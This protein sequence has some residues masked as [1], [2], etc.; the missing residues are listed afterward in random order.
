MIGDEATTTAGWPGTG[1]GQRSSGSDIDR[2]I[3][4]T[5]ESRRLFSNPTTVLGGLVSG[6]GIIERIEDD[7]VYFRSGDNIEITRQTDVFSP[8]SGDEPPRLVKA[9]VLEEGMVVSYSMRNGRIERL[10]LVGIVVSPPTGPTVFDTIADLELRRGSEVNDSID[11]RFPIRVTGKDGEVSISI[12]ATELIALPAP[13]LMVEWRNGDYRPESIDDFEQFDYLLVQWRD[14]GRITWTCYQSPEVAAANNPD[15]SPASPAA[16]QRSE[17]QER[18]RELERIQLLETAADGELD[19]GKRS[20][21]LRQAVEA[22]E[23]FHNRNRSQLAGLWA[24]FYQARCLQKLGDDEA[25]EEIIEDLLEVSGDGEGIRRFRAVMEQLLARP[26][27]PSDTG[28]TGLLAV[29]STGTRFVFVIDNSWSMASGNAMQAAK[30]ELTAGLQRLD[31]SQQFQI[32]FY[33]SEGI[34]VLR[35]QDRSADLFQGTDAQR[36]EA[37]SQ[38]SSTQPSGGTD[39]FRALRRALEFDPDTIFF[40]TDGSDPKLAAGER[41]ALVQTGSVTRIHCIEFGTGAAVDDSSNWLQHLARESGGT[42]VYAKLDTLSDELSSNDDES[43]TTTTGSEQQA[44]QKLQQLGATE[45]T[46]TVVDISDV[47]VTDEDLGVLAQLPRLRRLVLMDEPVT[48]DGRLVSTVLTDEVLKHLA[49]LE[50][51]ESL[52]V[53]YLPVT[54]MGLKELADLRTLRH[55][56]LRSTE[57][58]DASL[59]QLS[60]YSQLESLDLRATDITDAFLDQLVVLPRLTYLDIS[61]TTLPMKAS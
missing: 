19:S 27:N 39:H 29:P 1:G 50:H 32:I 61:S 2:Q 28:E 3:A 37:V 33:N 5:P 21:M 38:F 56:G 48:D 54:D 8:G 25:A 59:Q 16:D 57:I 40:L 24:Q 11:G 15:E 7:I 14:N 31:A 55:L 20:E 22:Y 30:A 13:T 34:D 46:A 47:V 49:T 26:V 41:A 6:G 45:A 36:L 10:V 18:Q 44:I 58:T 60:N 42:Y 51:L 17:I 12:G 53:N 9:N 43:G 23:V 35:P 4:S 52:D